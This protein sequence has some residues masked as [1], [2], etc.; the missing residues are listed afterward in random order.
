MSQG[1]NNFKRNDHHHNNNQNQN[2]D[3]FENI[4]RKYEQFLELH[5]SAR[6]KLFEMQG[7]VDNRNFKKLEQTFFTTQK[8]FYDFERNLSPE[9]KQ[10]LGEKIG[11]KPIDT[12]YSRAHNILNFQPEPIDATEKC[13]PHTL[14]SQHKIKF[15]SDNEESIGTFDDYKQLKGL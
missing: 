4:F 10:K 8:Q 1:R 11:E 6:R 5:I 2:R 15:S 13:D 7:S 14:D 9:T 3:Q 12:D